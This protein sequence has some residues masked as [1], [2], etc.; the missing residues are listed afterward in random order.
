[1]H[2]R[3]EAEARVWYETMHVASVEGLV[4]KP[5]RSHYEMGVRGWQKYKYRASAECVVGG[6]VGS[7]RR[8]SGLILGRYDRTGR[9]RVVG[10]TTRL[11]T[12]AAA[13]LAPLF[14][15]VSGAH[16]WPVPL[17]PGWAGSPYGQHEPITYTPVQPE[18]VVEVLVDTAV[19]KGRHRHPVKL[20]RVR[21]VL[22]PA[23][24]IEQRSAVA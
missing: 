19:E 23:H 1:M 9:L 14:V 3:D 11:T 24:V 5:V 15:P 4:I 22:E 8:P 10:R 7:P 20:L 16:P 13:E 2:T 18:V 17:P 12:Q 6:Y 21:T